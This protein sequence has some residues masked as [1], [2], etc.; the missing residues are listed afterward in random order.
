MF[1]ILVVGCLVI[2]VVTLYGIEFDK[3][4]S[5]CSKPVE[6]KFYEQPKQRT[7]TIGGEKEGR[8]LKESLIGGPWDGL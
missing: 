6:W 1:K 8:V 2:I 5:D 7:E 4:G 3:A